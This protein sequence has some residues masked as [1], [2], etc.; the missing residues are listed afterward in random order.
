MRLALFFLTLVCLSGCN[1]V[2]PY[3]V[4]VNSFSSAKASELQRYYVVPGNPSTTEDDLQ[5]QEAKFYLEQILQPKGFQPADSLAK[6]NLAIILTY[7]MGQPQTYTSTSSVPV[8]KQTGG[9]IHPYSQ[10]TYGIYG[11]QVTSGTIYQQP[12]YSVVGQETKITSK[13]V[14]SRWARIDA[15][16]MKEARKTNKV[17]SAWDTR[18][19]SSGTSGDLRQIIPVLIAG[20][21]DY[22]ATSTGRN[23][24]VVMTPQ[25]VN[26]RLLSKGQ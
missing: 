15:V 25:Q 14:Y 8:Y 18:I 17:T 23:V 5:F 21:K 26:A 1:S 10:V 11:A 9:G 3:T 7:G 19:E 4:S 6:A 22:V 16:D 13:T 12:T 24:D 2:H 20:A